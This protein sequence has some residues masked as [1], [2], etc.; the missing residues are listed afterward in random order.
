MHLENYLLLIYVNY[1]YVLQLL[2]YFIKI[3]QVILHLKFQYVN[4]L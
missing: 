4:D 1:I 2:F 3:T